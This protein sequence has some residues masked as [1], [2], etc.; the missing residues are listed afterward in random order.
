VAAKQGFA[1][2]EIA[3]PL[4]GSLAES[5]GLDVAASA[6]VGEHIVVLDRTGS[7]P[8]GQPGSA[9]MQR[10]PFAPPSGV[11]YVAWDTDEAVAQWLAKK[12]LT[13]MSG[14]HTHLRRVIASCR[15]RGYVVERLTEETRLTDRLL[16]G[17]GNRDIP[18][19]IREALGQA[20]STLGERDY[21][22]NELRP[23]D[24]VPVGGI[25]AP[26][27]SSDGRPELILSLGVLRERV[28]H[29]EI[30]GYARALLDVSQRVTAEVGGHDP[31]VATKL[32][33]RRGRS[34]AGRQSE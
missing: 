13:P 31:W 24:V 9:A 29:D 21:V 17:M 25:S 33:S 6:V 2:L 28:R 1:C 19:S 20:I 18:E 10:F 27:F 26:T 11:M 23:G 5:V 14:D 16:V 8:S 12:T 7:S 32:P 15:Q 30:E 34:S 4:M 22:T 3:R